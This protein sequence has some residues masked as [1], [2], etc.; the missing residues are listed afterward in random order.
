MKYLNKYTYVLLGLI[1]ISGITI[2]FI[3][4]NFQ[5]E[6]F[7]QDVID[8]IIE[9]VTTTSTTSVGNDNSEIVQNNEKPEAIEE[10]LI[11]TDEESNKIEKLLIN[12]TIKKVITD[13]DVYMLIGSDERSG[14]TVKTRGNVIG[15]LSLIHI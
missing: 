3:I 8:D 5:R 1:V 12:N 2:S 13:F 14:E 6:E 4:P 15:K 10:D 7:S 9:G 11:I